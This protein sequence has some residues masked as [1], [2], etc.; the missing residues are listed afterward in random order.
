MNHWEASDRA[1]DSPAA[2]GVRVLAVLTIWMSLAGPAPALAQPKHAGGS[3]PS[4][5]VLLLYGEPR[6]T[7]A[8]VSLDAVIRATLES[9][10]PVP[11]TFYTEYLD[12]NFFALGTPQPEL[13]ALLRRKYETRPLDLIVAAG[14]RALRIALHNRTD[15]FSSAPV[16]FAGVDRT[17]AADLRLDA[18]V[19]GTWLQMG[20]LETLDLARRLHP[21]TRRALVVTGSS[22]TDVVWRDEARRQLAAAEGAI[23]ISYPS[24]SV[25]DLL[26][27]VAALPRQTIVLVG[28]FLRDRTGRDVTTPEV[29]TRIA[30]ASRVPVYGLTDALVG[31]GI[32]G[33]QVVSF[34]A[35]GR[36]AGELGLRVLA[37]ER[38]P[39]T[40]RGTTVPMF[41]AR[42]LARWGV[43]SRR[44]PAESV[45]LFRESSVWERYRWYIAG[46]IAALLLQSGLIGALL[47]HRAQRR[48]AQQRLAER[49][50]F[51]TL[52]SDLSAIF[53]S[54][55]PA[56]TDR[57][58]E[59]G[60]R[61]IVEDLTLDWATVRDLQTGM[62]E[63]R[64]T[65]AWARD[66]VAPRP[67]VL[68]EDEAPWIFSKVRQ[69]QAVNL[70]RLGDLPEEA[71]VDRQ[72]FERLG[73]QSL[74]VVPLI[75]GSGVVGCLSVGTVRATHR[76][77]DELIPRLQL[78]A[79]VFAHALDRQRTARAVGEGEEQ[80]RSLAGRLMTAQEEE[81]RRIARDLH[82]DVN[83]ELAALSIALSAL[84]GRLPTGA[85]P[86][87]QGEVTG[88]QQR[89]A[90]LSEA[91][92]HL[93][94]ELHPGA[95]PHVGLVAALRGY[96]RTFEREHGLA[97]A[98]QADGTLDDVPSDLALCFYRVT[99]E[100]L[101]NAVKHA[102]ARHVRVTVGRDGSNVTLI[103]ADDGRG[104]DLVEARGRSGLGLISLD[105]RVRLAGGRLTIATNHQRGTELRIVVPLAETRD[106]SPHRTPR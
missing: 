83:Q 35:H 7:P 54:G 55:T 75:V 61:R 70:A 58:I 34:E 17:A 2:G 81:R 104:F 32:V 79:Q 39:P 49:L 10:S 19:T 43:D 62:A 47:V 6:L 37:G 13:R 94:H 105:E 9:R 24:L 48:R 12:L 5:R 41:D 36:A 100:G 20:W 27:E 87:L 66:G 106:A 56:E 73:T 74:V 78:L 102:A 91:I 16:V 103:I 96:C 82:D 44:L 46:A 57:Q 92:R 53:A 8:I 64:L 85:T 77:H 52:L 26:K 25:D 31:S 84:A 30:A 1:S 21:G 15:L 42:Q 88:L 95:L 71:P 22:P 59:T 63:I 65:H 97:I 40:S 51:E 18:D 80:V 76:W 38:P 90:E 11:V 89:T 23:E 45:V 93:S 69:G 3:E 14:S 101:G 29:T 60:L 33:G 86:D 67:A 50:Q 4:R 68:R 99:Q 28:T 72:S 98:F